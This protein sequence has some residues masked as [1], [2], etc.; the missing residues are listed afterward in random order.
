M[1]VLRKES[2]RQVIGYRETYFGPKQNVSVSVIGTLN[3]ITTPNRKTG[4]VEIQTVF[5]Q[6]VLPTPQGK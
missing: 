2:S 5:G 1:V 6:A 4:G 3:T